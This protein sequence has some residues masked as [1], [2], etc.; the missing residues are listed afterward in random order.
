MRQF[1]LSIQNFNTI[2]QT[3][4]QFQ[5]QFSAKRSRNRARILIVRT[6]TKRHLR[7]KKHNPSRIL[8][9]F[10]HTFNIHLFI[11]LIREPQHLCFSLSFF[12]M[13]I[14]VLNIR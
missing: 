1:Y 4:E 2:Q 8:D 13:D 12:I 5:M 14:L 9:L 3:K 6:M 11:E 7:N 10:Q